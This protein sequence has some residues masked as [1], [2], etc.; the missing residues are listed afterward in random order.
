MQACKDDVMTFSP[1]NMPPAYN[2][3]RSG[4]APPAGDLT[5]YGQVGQ[6]PW[7]FAQTVRGAVATLA[8]WLIFIIGTQLL[9]SPSGTS[10]QRQLSTAED[11]VGAVF[12]FFITGI[13]ELAFV[14]APAYY[15]LVRRPPGITPHQGLAALGLRPT[16]LSPAI[17]ATV[18]GFLVIIGCNVTYS[19]LIQ[20]FNLPLHTNSDTLLQQAK[21]APITTLALVAGAV[22][23]APFCEE[24]FFRGF[25]FGGLLHQMSFW[26][27]ALL[28][29]F[30]FALAHGDVGSFIVLFIFGVVLAF[31]RWR[32]GSIWPGIVIHA[33]N[34]ATAAVAIIL[35]LTAK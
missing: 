13:V 23:V 4:D 16:R 20:V 14:I 28:S 26:P 9:T 15:A 27:A 30:L 3:D 32:T 1:G 31:V 24:L 8:P 17:V 11:I 18:V 34:N 5:R 7:T 19:Y 35:A 2:T 29:A 25:L 21:Y 12:A 33:A 22:L 6:T 10:G